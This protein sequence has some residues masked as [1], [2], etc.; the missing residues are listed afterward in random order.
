G[1]RRLLAVC[2]DLRDPHQRE[3]LPVTAPAARI[4]AAALLEDDDRV[5]ARVF[6]DLGR[7]EGTG[8]RRLADGRPVAAAHRHPDGDVFS[9]LRHELAEAE[10]LIFGVRV[11]F[12]ACLDDREHR[13]IPSFLGEGR[14]L[15]KARGCKTRAVSLGFMA[16]WVVCVKKRT[17]TQPRMSVISLNT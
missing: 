2:Q 4:L 1:L 7:N 9:S 3:I 10:R 8:D 16:G 11:L 14:A 13:A 6:D 15:N 5:A 12:A 17:S